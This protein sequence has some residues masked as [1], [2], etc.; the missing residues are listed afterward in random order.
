[1]GKFKDLTGMTFGKLTVIK[2]NGKDKYGKILWKC[3][4]SCGNEYTTHGRSLTN[5]HCKS[6]GCLLKENRLEDSKYKG[7]TNTRIF[8]IWKGMVY[9]CTSPKCDCYDL[10]GGRGIGVCPEWTGTQ[11]FFNFLKWSLENGYS[12]ELTIDRINTNGNY[13]P[14]NCRWADWETQANNRRKPEKAVNQ[15]GVWDYRQPLPVRYQPKGE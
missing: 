14:N 10:Y 11:G 5:G 13:E 6:C 9:R 7:F 8:T 4:C 12:H 2:Q 15:Y 1:M 3:K